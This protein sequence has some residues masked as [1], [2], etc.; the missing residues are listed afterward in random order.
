MGEVFFMYGLYDQAISYYSK[1][2]SLNPHFNNSQYGLAKTLIVNGDF[3]DALKEINAALKI[4]AFQSRFLNLRGLVLLWQ[5]RPDDAIVS[6]S[7][8]MRISRNKQKYFYNL[9]VAFSQAGYYKQAEWFLKLSGTSSIDIRNLFSLLEN[10][11]RSNNQQQINYLTEKIIKQFSLT[12]IEQYLKNMRHDY[13]S[14][15]ISSNLISPVI[16]QHIRKK[17]RLLPNASGMPPDKK[18][19]S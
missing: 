17:V 9:G 14:V 4:D 6:I 19:S 5:N 7:R 12:Y 1:S 8:A 13:R 16:Y 11:I 18:P 2:L 10:S 3:D 15:P